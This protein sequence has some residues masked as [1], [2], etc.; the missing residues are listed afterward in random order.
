MKKKVLIVPAFESS[1]SINVEFPKT[2]ESLVMEWNKG[3]V[4]YNPCQSPNLATDA[5][6]WIEKTASRSQCNRLWK[7]EGIG[8]SVRGNGHL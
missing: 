3:N 1:T 4:G 2:K 8:I 6:L 7:M 5:A